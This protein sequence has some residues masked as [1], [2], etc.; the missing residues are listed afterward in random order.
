MVRPKSALAVLREQLGLTQMELATRLGISQGELSYYET[1]QKIPSGALLAS[2]GRLFPEVETPADLLLS[3][4]EY[5]ERK[6][7]QEDE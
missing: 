5:V 3:Y 1:G 4:P 2:M 7:Q 6:H